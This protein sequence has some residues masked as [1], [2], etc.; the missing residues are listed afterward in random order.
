MALAC[1]FVG[2]AGDSMTDCEQALEE[3]AH[4]LEVPIQPFIVSLTVCL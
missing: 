3:D 4:S 2:A 1:V